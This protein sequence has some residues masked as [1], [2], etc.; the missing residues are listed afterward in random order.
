MNE[1]HRL[2]W[3]E[4]ESEYA[5]YLWGIKATTMEISVRLGKSYKA[6]KNKLRRL[7]HIKRVGGRLWTKEASDFLQARIMEG[8][9]SG[10]IAVKMA[11]EFGGQYTRNKIVGRAYRMGLHGS[12]RPQSTFR[13]PVSSRKGIKIGPR[14]SSRVA[15]SIEVAKPDFLGLTFIENSGCMYTQEEGP[16]FHFCGQGKIA[17]YGFCPYHYS[18]CY[19]SHRFSHQRPTT[20]LGAVGTS[21]VV[22]PGP[23]GVPLISVAV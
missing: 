20:P 7:G 12:N 17:G 18:L 13:L 19:K 16:D 5:L 10:Q 15:R 23:A 14:S 11:E 22:P 9:S 2:W 21:A 8:W 1:A 3:S 6:V 4:A